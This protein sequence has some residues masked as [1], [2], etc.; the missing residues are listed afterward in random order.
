MLERYSQELDGESKKAVQHYIL[1]DEYEMAFEGLCVELLKLEETKVDWDAC[2]NIA[3]QL[4]LD[5]DSVFDSEL[6]TKI[7]RRVGLG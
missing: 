2:L 5:K 6:W 4:G 3:R 7:S 1:H